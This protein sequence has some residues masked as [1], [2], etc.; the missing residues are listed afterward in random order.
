MSAGA[1]TSPIILVMGNF[2]W[3]HTGAGFMWMILFLGLF[4]MGFVVERLIYIFA[5]SNKGRKEFLANVSVLIKQGKL[6]EAEALAKKTDIPVGRAIAAVLAKRSEGRE[7][8]ENELHEVLLTE[9]PRL[10]RY[11]MFIMTLAN[12]ATL[13]GLLGTLWGLIAAFNAVANLP[14]AERPKALTAAISAKMGTTFMGLVVA[15]PLMV[16]Y[17]FLQLNAERLAQE[18]EEKA[19][20]VINQLSRQA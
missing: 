12:V 8:M 3:E 18:V 13:M 6:D 5:K 9:E 20:K 4:S 1:T 10:M 11:L 7:G 2:N 16:F 19:T 17:G 14:P 15:V